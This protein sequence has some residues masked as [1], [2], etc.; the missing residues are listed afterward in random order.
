MIRQILMA[1]DQL[2]NALCGG[3]ADESISA[4]AWRNGW[5]WRIRLINAVFFDRRHC[6]TSYDA[7]QQ[8]LQLPPAYRDAR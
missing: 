2:V 4:R 6:Q 7:E 3:W 8:R 1:L 5:T